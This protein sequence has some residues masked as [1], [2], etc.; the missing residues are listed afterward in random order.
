MS[1]RTSIFIVVKISLLTVLVAQQFF[2]SAP[3]EAC[4]QE[5]GVYV[6]GSGLTCD[7]ATI[8]NKKGKTLKI[9]KARRVLNKKIKKLQGKRGKKAKKRRQ[10]LRVTKK[11]LKSC[12]NGELEVLPT[13]IPTPTPGD[14]V[15][16]ELS[17]EDEL[18]TNTTYDATL[19]FIPA[20]VGRSLLLQISENGGASWDTVA[21]TEGDASGDSPVEY[22]TPSSAGTY[23][24]R[25]FAE[26]TNIS[27]E[28]SGTPIEVTIS[29]CGVAIVPKKLPLVRAGGVHSCL[30]D[31]N[32]EAWCWGENT[33]GAVGDGTDTDRLNPVKVSGGHKFIDIEL[34]AR[35]SC[36]LKADGTA[37]CWGKD[38]E[39]E[40]Q[41]ALGGGSIGS[42]DVPTKVAGGIK[43]AK[44][45]LGQEHTCGIA[46]NGST[47]CWG[48]NRHGQIGDG[49]TPVKSDS[50]N[51]DATE[52]HRY[53]PTR[54]SGSQNFE[55]IV[56]KGWQ[57]CARTSSG[58][59][60]CWGDSPLGCDTCYKNN[61]NMPELEQSQ[62]FASISIGYSHRCGITF[63]GTAYCWGT[64]SQGEFGN[65]NET[66]DPVS[67]TELQAVE[68]SVSFASIHA[69]NS[70]TCGLK[71]NGEAY[72][73]GYNLLGA[74]GDG[75]GGSTSLNRHEPREVFT[76]REF[77]HLSA[78]YGHTCAVSLGGSAYC[79][80]GNN[81]GQLGIGI[82]GFGAFRSTPTFVGFS[83]GP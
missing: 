42:K 4:A 12:T 59:M 13:P 36:A 73:W 16:L 49:A 34:G 52:Y 39:F 19:S 44:L 2:V 63:S 67:T 57:T 17:I 40:S 74:V 68:G 6:L 71:S 27:G 48:N 51:G 5:G 37:Y 18:C 33:Y 80:G 72:C 55:D 26:S 66:T 29:D 79:W 25:T 54:V 70:F 61:S 53:S 10:K 9:K 46:T 32:G 64:E 21:V 76:I 58:S 22:D 23:H 28:K 35:H 78:G 56:A 62:A 83:T 7:A 65:G 82:S 24:Y 11:L 30:L 75:T 69:G 1:K 15:T 47:Y 8:L 38:E 14:D 20:Q 41:G 81:Q 50:Y 77:D 31:L 45:A 3:N 60:Y 43:F